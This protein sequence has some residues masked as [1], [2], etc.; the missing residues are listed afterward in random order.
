MQQIRIE[1]ELLI[2]NIEFKSKLDFAVNKS[3]DLLNAMATYFD[4]EYELKKMY[5]AAIPDFAAGK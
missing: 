4:V 1:L 2:L 3:Y 5:S